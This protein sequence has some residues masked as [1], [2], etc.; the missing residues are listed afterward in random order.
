MRTFLPQPFSF[1]KEKDSI[2]H[3]TILPISKP[4]LLF[5]LVKRCERHELAGTVTCS[6]VHRD[7]LLH[8]LNSTVLLQTLPNIQAPATFLAGTGF[9]VSLSAMFLCTPLTTASLDPGP[10]PLLGSL[11]SISSSLRAKGVL[12]N[13][14]HLALA[15]RSL[16][17]FLLR[18]GHSL[19]PGLRPCDYIWLFTQ[20]N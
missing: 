15:F 20:V 9:Q 12:L 4:P 14:Q 19:G 1:M 13:G 8:S 7:R 10:H 5:L 18:Q 2:T 6:S 16:P 11:C 17:C 3:G